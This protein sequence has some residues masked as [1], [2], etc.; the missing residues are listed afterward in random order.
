MALTL[1]TL[2]RMA[3]QPSTSPR[4]RRP[5]PTTSS[6]MTRLPHCPKS[7]N[8]LFCFSEENLQQLAE[9]HENIQRMRLE[10]AAA[11]ARPGVASNFGGIREA[12]RLS[13]SCPSLNNSVVDTQDMENGNFEAGGHYYKQTP[14]SRN[15]P[16]KK[17]HNIAADIRNSNSQ[18]PMPPGH[19]RTKRHGRRRR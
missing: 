5:M 6:V 14:T 12:N 16:R 4:P 9:I 8:K 3:F 10:N 11:A 18:M 13:N 1:P 7:L 17:P 19:G 2:A 15:P